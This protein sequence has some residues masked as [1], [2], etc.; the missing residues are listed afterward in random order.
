MFSPL[1]AIKIAALNYNFWLKA[2][3]IVNKQ[4]N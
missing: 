1:I 4:Q 3:Q 2:A